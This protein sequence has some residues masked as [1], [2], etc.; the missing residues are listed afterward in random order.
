MSVSPQ[1]SNPFNPGVEVEILEA[2]VNTLFP[3]KKRYP[4]S[5]F[6]PNPNSYPK[7]YPN[8]NSNPNLTLFPEIDSKKGVKERNRVERES[9]E[10]GKKDV[11]ER[12]ENM[13]IYSG[14]GSF[15]LAEYLEDVAQVRVR[16]RVGVR[17]RVRVNPEPKHDF[18]Q[19]ILMSLASR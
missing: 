9:D 16:V 15:F 17:V 10:M 4:N 12:K 5:N 1:T 18:P 6:N 19:F 3:G 14:E 2:I 13:G 7:S 11:E 8:P